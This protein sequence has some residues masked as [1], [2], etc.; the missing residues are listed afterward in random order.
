[1]IDRLRPLFSVRRLRRGLFEAYFTVDPRSLG[2]CRIGLGLLLLWDLLRRVPEISIWYSN[3][4]LLPNHT[5]LW[6]PG[7]EYMFSFFFAAST[8]QEAACMFFLCALV[9]ALF[10]VGYRTRLMHVL[11]FACIVSLH[12]RG[13]FLE[14]GGDVVLNV[15]CAWTLF[16]PLGARFSVDAVLSSLRAR[17]E[18]TIGELN[19]RAA[20]PARDILPRRSLASLAI[21]IEL[22]LIYYLNALHKTGWTWR[23]GSAVHY[24]FYQERM[25]TWF[26][27]LVRPYLQPWMTLRMTYTTWNIE[28]LAPILILNPLFFTWTRRVAMVLLP[29]LHL[30]FAAVL[31]LGQFTFNMIGFYPLLLG[32]RDW[33]L[34]ARWFAPSATRART[35]LV[36]ERSPHAM[37][38]ARLLLRLDAFERL[39]FAPLE[40]A[41]SAKNGTS[42]AVENPVTRER[43]IGAR[44]LAECLA[45][46]PCCL[47]LAAVL[48]VTAV[49]ALLELFLEPL[50]TWLLRMAVAHA[51]ARRAPAPSPARQWWS[52]GLAGARE[53][54][55]VVA[56]VALGSQVLME[57]KVIPA[58][59][60]VQS[61]WMQQFV[62]YPRLFQGW[63]MF[64]PDVPTGERMVYVDALTVTGRHVD[65]YNEAGS[66]V[67]DLPVER[68]PPHMEQ[69]EFWCDFTNRVPDNDTYWKPLKAWIF[70]YPNRTGNPD[71]RI[72]SF[73]AKLF[74]QDNPP[75]GEREPR[76]PRTRVM[77]RGYEGE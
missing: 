1:V 77:F 67:A 4:G 37:A 9:F 17:R 30:A 59:Y 53:I 27:L 25:V 36:D 52:R 2:L 55:V 44:A 18:T 23:Q 16:L 7:A 48:R 61:K 41:P 42:F 3:Q 8:V 38:L 73:E 32:P 15:L 12:S 5:A 70:D 62:T 49:R 29:G 57:N 13:I 63:F 6:R 33:R 26:G 31:N 24:V 58:K 10:T 56:M 20:L 11:S 19:D 43:T 14:N 66:R 54:A 75:P 50:A 47:P 68:I 28:L 76:N 22:A 74:E 65:P 71:D 60:K 72:V 39:S 34:L 46:L 21:L 51:A 64:S 45:A 40:A 69:N 35:V